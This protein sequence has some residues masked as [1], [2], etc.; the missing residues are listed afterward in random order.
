MVAPQTCDSVRA[1]SNKRRLGF[2]GRTC[3]TGLALPKRRASIAFRGPTHP[4]VA[5]SRTSPDLERERVSLIK[6]R[7]SSAG[8]KRN[9]RYGGDSFARGRGA[10]RGTK[11]KAG[12]RTGAM[13]FDQG[14]AL[15]AGA[16]CP[17]CGT[18][19]GGAYCEA[20]C[21]DRVSLTGSS[22]SSVQSTP[23]KGVNPGALLVSVSPTKKN[24]SAP[25]RAFMPYRETVLRQPSDSWTSWTLRQPVF[26]TPPKRAARHLNAHV[27]HDPVW[28]QHCIGSDTSSTSDSSSKR[29]SMESA[30]LSLSPRSQRDSLDKYT[31]SAERQLRESVKYA[32]GH[33]LAPNRPA[34]PVSEDEGDN[35]SMRI[36]ISFSVSFLTQHL[37]QVFVIGSIPELASWKVA[38]ARPLTC[39]QDET[40]NEFFWKTSIEIDTSR[41]NEFEYKYFAAIPGEWK[42]LRW[43]NRFNRRAQIQDVDT[44]LGETVLNDGFFKA[45]YRIN[46]KLA[47]GQMLYL[48]GEP[49]E[50]GN[51]NPENAL[52]LKWN[53]GHCWDLR[54]VLRTSLIEHDF[55]FKVLQYRDDYFSLDGSS[56]HRLWSECT[57]VKLAKWG[58]DWEVDDAAR[59]RALNLDAEYTRRSPQLSRR[60][61]PDLDDILDELDSL[62]T[63]NQ[64]LE[65]QMARMRK[66]NVDLKES[67]GLSPEELRLFRE[68]L[69]NPER[70]AELDGLELEQLAQKLDRLIP[71]SQ[72]NTF[73]SFEYPKG[74]NPSLATQTQKVVKV[75][76]NEVQC[77]PGTLGGGR[78]AADEDTFKLASADK[79]RSVQRQRPARRI[80]IG[81]G[82]DLETEGRGDMPALKRFHWTKIPVRYLRGSVW[83]QIRQDAWC[84]SS[85]D[86][87]NTHFSTNSGKSTFARA[88]SILSRGKQLQVLDSKT[89]RN[90]EIS[91]K[92][93]KHLS[94]E[95]IERAIVRGDAYAFTSEEIDILVSILP[96]SEDEGRMLE[97]QGNDD[98]LLEPERFYVHMSR[99]ERV[100]RKVECLRTVNTFESEFHLLKIQAR[101]VLKACEEIFDA[102]PFF[103][104]LEFC[105]AL[106]NYLNEGSSKGNANGFSV[107]DLPTMALI[108]TSDRKSSLLHYA[109][110]VM[111]AHRPEL[112]SFIDCIGT[113]HR[114]SKIDSRAT[115]AEFRELETALGCVR[116]EKDI[117]KAGKTMPEFQRT[118]DEFLRT[119]EP[120]EVDLRGLVLDLEDAVKL[121]LMFLP[122]SRSGTGPEE[123]FG[124]I[125]IFVKQCKTAYMEVLSQPIFNDAGAQWWF[126]DTTPQTRITPESVAVVRTQRIVT[127]RIAPRSLNFDNDADSKANGPSLVPGL[128]IPPPPPAPFMHT[129]TASVGVAVPAPPP[130]PPPPSAGACSGR[131]PPPAPPP[132][133]AQAD[134][135]APSRTATVKFNPVP[136]SS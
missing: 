112:F 86:E 61:E 42:S 128:Q 102:D 113:V 47:F 79:N 127:N 110:A 5:K 114:A 72:L 103:H 124:A 43:E 136:E 39:V 49:H 59:E 118:M 95:Y 53:P 24:K 126:D 57:E 13:L 71:S 2:S 62:K 80:V 75:S 58:E 130:P 29:N 117:C 8:I 30:V 51:W 116:R 3:A 66:E 34:S 46:C 63:K 89:A 78:G 96:N 84:I 91:M 93:L 36:T 122:S 132:A 21:N 129:S 85:W 7:T 50:L 38:E 16:T 35:I 31:A 64:Y 83:T 37:E 15:H 115:V 19:T 10:R 45:R 106:G 40:T 27:M 123:I 99:L 135:R 1:R 108:L 23:Q 77:L 92:R 56:K 88:E 67:Q 28:Q 54:L 121:L 107:L 11:T 90:I 94:L 65:E 33:E 104:V 82:K 133:Q 9:A 105:L 60:S 12:T 32:T 17:G 73:A 134:A 120:L 25:A 131:I 68:L 14:S 4:F 101:T 109:V 48:L 52:A 70:K 20:V 111:R 98:D 97:Y 69:R 22:R 76:E 87:L 125:A 74:T 81:Q 6:L 44:N 55:R 18:A 41:V 119:I 100:R 26:R